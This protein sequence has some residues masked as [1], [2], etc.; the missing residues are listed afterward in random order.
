ME[1][2]KTVINIEKRELNWNGHQWEWWIIDSQ[3][4]YYRKEELGECGKVGYE[5]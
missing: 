1:Q 3:I 5:R 2:P 4:N